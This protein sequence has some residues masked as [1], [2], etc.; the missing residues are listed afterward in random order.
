MCSFAKPI[1]CVAQW[2]YWMLNV[3]ASIFGIM[4]CLCTKIYIRSLKQ[5]VVMC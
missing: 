1:N 2:I 4:S 3:I 5:I